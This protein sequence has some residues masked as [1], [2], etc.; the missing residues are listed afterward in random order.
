MSIY[1][2]AMTG[3]DAHNGSFAAPFKTIGQAS[4]VGA[5][6]DT[7]QITAGTYYETISPPEMD[8]PIM[9]T[10]APMANG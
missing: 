6:G 5:A 8:S 1:Y 9:A 7:I 2:V 3:N 4:K 10:E